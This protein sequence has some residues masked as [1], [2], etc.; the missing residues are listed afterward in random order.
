VLLIV[1]CSI[2]AGRFILGEIFW[3]NTGKPLWILLT[4][5][6]DSGLLGTFRFSPL[7]RLNKLKKI[8]VN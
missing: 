8:E 4:P 3:G 5:I 7:E 1:L 6:G 2:H